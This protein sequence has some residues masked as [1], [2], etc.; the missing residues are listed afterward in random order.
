MYAA[1]YAH[2]QL[3]DNPAVG[4]G[5]GAHQFNYLGDNYDLR[6]I[7]EDAGV[8]GLIQARSRAINPLSVDGA[9]A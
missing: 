1:G 7:N 6:T 9:A 2:G 4:D 8:R 3:N 5:T